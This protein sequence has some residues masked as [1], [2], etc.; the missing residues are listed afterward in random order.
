M[1]RDFA[2]LKPEC[3]TA[4]RVKIEEKKTKIEERRRERGGLVL[5]K[6][7]SKYSVALLRHRVHSSCLLCFTQLLCWTRKLRHS[8]CERW[9]RINI[10]AIKNNIDTTY[11]LFLLLFEM[12]IKNLHKLKLLIMK[13]KFTTSF[14]PLQKSGQI[15]TF[16][17]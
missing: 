5:Q 17:Y 13:H 10:A 14:I 1:A 8:Q 16:I 12:K 4:E 11:K 3:H 7:S 6:Y 2:Y 15:M 9:T